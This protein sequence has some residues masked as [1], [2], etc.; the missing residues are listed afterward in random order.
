MLTTIA[1]QDAERRTLHEALAALYD[2][3]SWRIT[4]PFR[5]FSAMLFRSSTK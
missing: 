4:R 3:R 5:S 1:A 2:S